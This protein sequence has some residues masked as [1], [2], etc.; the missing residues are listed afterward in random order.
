[1]II[2]GSIVM[3][4]ALYSFALMN[5]SN[6]E[7][8]I[9][10]NWHEKKWEYEKVY[11]LEDKKELD[12]AGDYEIQHIAGN[13]LIIHMGEQWKF[14]PDGELLFYKNKQRNTAKWK[15][16]GRGNILEIQYQDGLSEHY[17]I[18]ELNQQQLVLNFNA[19]MQIKGIT[20][21]TFNRS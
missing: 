10:G 3:L 7:D 18:V 12:A 4:L 11:Q 19:D 13:H 15:I 2:L 20:K 6:P 16:K 17:N 8:A 1:M 21:L 5:L 9:V 14:M